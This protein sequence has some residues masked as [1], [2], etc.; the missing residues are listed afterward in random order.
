MIPFSDLSALSG[1]DFGAYEDI[2]SGQTVTGSSTDLLK[3][4]YF[5]QR[6]PRETSSTLDMEANNSLFNLLKGGN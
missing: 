3:G 1:Y 2:V 5:G 4:L 6:K